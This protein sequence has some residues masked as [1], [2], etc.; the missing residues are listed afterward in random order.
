MRRWLVLL[1]ALPLLLLPAA[2][3]LAHAA[4]LSTD[5]EDGTVL[6]AAPESV[7]LRFS[8]P[9]GTGL[10][11]VRVIDPE[12]ERV[13][14]GQPVRGEGG[15]EVTVGLRDTEAEGTYVLTWRVVS[16]D[17]HPVS[18]VS[19]FSVGRASEP[20]AAVEAAGAG[21]AKRWLTLVRGLGYVGLLAMV[22]ATALL[23][24]VWPGGRSQATVRRFLGSA[25]LLTVLSA[26]GGLL[27]QG[28][29]AAGLGVARALDGDLLTAVLGTQYGKAHVAR[30]VLLL[31]AG[32]ALLALLRSRREL[33]PAGLLVAGA[34]AAPLLLTWPLSGHAAAGELRWLA[35]P[36]DA[37]HLLAV[38][39]W[40]GGLLVLCTALL[41]RGSEQ[42]LASALPRWSRLAQ[43]AVLLMVIT[44]VFAAWR[45]V[46]GLDP[47][48]GTTYGQLLVLKT[49]AVVLMLGIGNTGRHWVRRRYTM[50]LVHAATATATADRPAPTAPQLGQLRRGVLAESCIALAVVGLTA[51]LVETPPARSAYAEPLSVIQDLGPDSKVQIDLDS[52]RVG[53]NALHVYLTGPGGKAFD[54]PEVTAR[55][56][57]ADGES[58][59]SPVAR[60][61]LGHYETLRLAVPYRGTWRLDVTVRTSDI[62]VETATL[63]TTF[64]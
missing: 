32:I 22:G 62:D 7:T 15:R 18:G 63:T 19:T 56:S 9:V 57:R 55:L 38:G 17:A 30:L 46:R 3:A 11:A 6:A 12:G 54:V 2:P 13:D 64:R 59:T 48:T 20:A 4:L 8:E 50:Q 16:E 41:R 35:L 44:G 40:T 21:P 28:P 45:E 10:G 53:V 34:L 31:V 27:L 61:S 24:L 29:T 60:K 26:A 58:L 1:L 36:V 43:G 52:A 25:W 5:P 14:D 42:E 33:R 49:T 37:V 47:L 23:L 39:A 51:V